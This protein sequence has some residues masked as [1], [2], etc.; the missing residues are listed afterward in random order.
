V[1]EQYDGGV[2]VVY[3]I[4]NVSVAWVLMVIYIAICR[5]QPI[6]ETGG[7]T[8]DRSVSLFYFLWNRLRSFERLSEYLGR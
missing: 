8:G 2:F 4:F 3:A 1:L 6:L 5:N 7:S